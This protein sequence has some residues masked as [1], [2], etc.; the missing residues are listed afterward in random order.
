MSVV[1]T[2][3]SRGLGL[4]IVTR[5]LLDGV[6]VIATS[7]SESPELLS[8]KSEYADRLSYFACDLSQ[9]VEDVAATFADSLPDRVMFDGF[10]NNAAIAY[11]DLVTNAK[12]AELAKM[13]QVNTIVPI[14]L[15]RFAIRRMLL[16][17]IRGSLVHVTSVCVHTGYKG[18]TMYA[19]SKGAIEAFS[20]NVAREWG[21]MGIRSNCVVPGFMDTDMSASLGNSQKHKIFR[22][23]ALGEATCPD[24]VAA[25]VGHLLSND[26]SSTTGQSIRVD[27]G[28]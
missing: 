20:R 7:R 17:S 21:P 2:G 3:A 22:R 25:M 15:T 13:M 6:D 1:V 26:A 12:P 8:L 19:A 27:A 5:L 23:T 11:D 16:H 10:V 4:A 14:M 24:S 9:P 18:L 28:T